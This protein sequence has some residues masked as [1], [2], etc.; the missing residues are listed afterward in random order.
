MS[1]P[2]N[3]DNRDLRE[4]RMSRQTTQGD[5]RRETDPNPTADKQKNQQ[6]PG[7]NNDQQQSKKAK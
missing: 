4:D 3:D 6:M 7:K 1:E 5:N 2:R